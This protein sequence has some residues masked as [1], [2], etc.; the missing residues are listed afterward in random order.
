MQKDNIEKNLRGSNSGTTVET[1]TADKLKQ[2]G[3]QLISWCDGLEKYGL[4]DWQRAVWE[5]EIES[6]KCLYVLGMLNIKH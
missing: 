3:D 6:S 1:L 4:V 5:E 2:M